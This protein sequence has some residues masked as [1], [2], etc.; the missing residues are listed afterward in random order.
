MQDFASLQHQISQ[1]TLTPTEE[2]Y[3]EPGWVILRNA[4]EAGRALLAIR[5]DTGSLQVPTSPKEE[6][7]RQ[8]QR[9]LLDSSARRFQAKRI[10]LRGQAA[11]RW[12]LQRRS[13]LQGQKPN[14]AHVLA[15]QALNN[16]LMTEMAIV[17]DV[18]VY[19]MLRAKDQQAGSWL[20]E[21]PSLA[22]ILGWV[23]AQR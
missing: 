22:N 10:C 4:R 5:F 17:T 21:D 18:Y 6:Q 19:N 13:L 14:V 11:T 20:A 23:Q 7:K 9:I 12:A 1:M 3:N 16:Q 8:L 2:E 15:L